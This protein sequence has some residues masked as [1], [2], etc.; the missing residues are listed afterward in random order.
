M[1][2]CVKYLKKAFRLARETHTPVLFHVE[3]IN[4]AT[5]AF[6]FG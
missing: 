1:P 5:G 4:T 6:H 2:A 3:E